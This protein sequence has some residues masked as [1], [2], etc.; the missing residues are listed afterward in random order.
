MEMCKF[1]I[2][3]N[4]PFP[5]SSPTP[6]VQSIYVFVTMRYD[7]SQWVVSLAAEHKTKSNQVRELSPR[8]TT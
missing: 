6:N 2:L 1:L 8:F 4:F 7:E 3:A 5:S